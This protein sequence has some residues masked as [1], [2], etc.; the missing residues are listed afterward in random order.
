MFPI[1]LLISALTNSNVV[2]LNMRAN[3]NKTQRASLALFA[4]VF[5]EMRSLI[6]MVLSQARALIQ[7]NSSGCTDS[8]KLKGVGH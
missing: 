7:K 1:L 6:Q 8:N 5:S 4:M 2:V 3:S